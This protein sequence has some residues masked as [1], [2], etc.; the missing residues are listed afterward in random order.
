MKKQHI[1]A[2]LLFLLLVSSIFFPVQKAFADP[3][4]IPNGPNLYQINRTST[5]A[6]L[7]FTPI[8]DGIKSYTIAYG[9]KVDDEKYSITFNFGSSTGA[10]SYTIN[11]LDPNFQYYFR[12]RANTS[13]TSSPWSAWVGDKHTPSSS[14]S[15]S[16]SVSAGVSSLPPPG[17]NTVM[18]GFLIS[19][20]LILSGLTLFKFSTSLS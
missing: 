15:Q 9:L 7:F 19:L 20:G 11:D 17:S 10:V 5:Q 16:S 12:V 8:N 13:C 3:C 4:T 1:K 6:T 14:S 2:A 18:I